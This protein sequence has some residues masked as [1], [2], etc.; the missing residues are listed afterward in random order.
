MNK[1]RLNKTESINSINTKNNIDIKMENTTNTL[2]HLEIIKDVDAYQVF[3]NEKEDCNVYRLILTINPYC[4]NILF[5]TF[6]EITRNEGSKE[7]D[8]NNKLECISDNGE[9]TNGDGRKKN[10]G[11]D[12][13]NRQ[14][15]IMNTEYSK[16]DIGYEYH[17]GYDIF[18]NHIIR[19]L[20]FKLV[21]D[22]TDETINSLSSN[23]TED[24]CGT[25]ISWSDNNTNKQNYLKLI[26]NTIGDVMRYS[27]GRVIQYRKREK[28]DDIPNKDLNKHL[29]LYDDIL[30]YE[31]S[32]NYNLREENGWFGITNNS[33]VSAKVKTDQYKPSTKQLIW[34]DLDIS[35]FINNRENCEFI[36][37]YPDR[38][39]FSFNPILNTFRKR[40]EY[41]WDVILTYPYRNE[42]CHD[43]IMYKDENGNEVNGLKIMS[44]Q[45]NNGT[46]S[47]S[48]V[49]FRTFIKHGLKKTDNVKIFVNGKEIP[50]LFQVT[51]TGNMTDDVSKEEYYFYINDNS[52]LSEYLIDDVQTDIRFRK[53]VNGMDSEYYIRVFKKLPNFKNK[54]EKLTQDIVLDKEKYEN[55]LYGENLN[56]SAVQDYNGKKEAYLIDFNKE[57]YKLAFSRTIYNDASTQITFTDDIDVKYL[58]DNIGRPLHEFYITI[59]KTNNGYKEWYGIEHINDEYRRMSNTDIYNDNV[60]FSHCFGNLTSGFDISNEE[61]DAII[62][63]NENEGN[64]IIYK[65]G[66]IGDIHLL[67]EL[68]L[69]HS[70][71]YE[72]EINNHGS[73]LLKD[74]FYGDIVEFIPLECRENILQ[75]INYRFNTA[76]RE[77]PLD[78]IFNNFVY[79]EIKYDD[80]D[81]KDY[82]ITEN[83]VESYV[84]QYRKE[85]KIWQR[86]EGYYYQAH[87]PITIK[88]FG[89]INQGEHYDISVKSISPKQNGN[90]VLEVISNLTC[91]VA[92]GDIIFLCLDN[93]SSFHSNKKYYFNVTEKIN[94]NTIRISP[95]NKSWNELW[96]EISQD[97]NTAYTQWNWIILCNIIKE[98]KIYENNTE[99]VSYS[100]KLRAKNKSIPFYAKQID[101]NRFLWRDIYKIGEYENTTNE[102]LPYTNNAFYIN[103]EINFFL[104]RQDSHNTHGLYCSNAF[105]NDI[106]GE[107]SKEDIYYYKDDSENL[108]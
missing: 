46:N 104:K 95:Y 91:N 49:I 64:N 58:I 94:K 36:D 74:E 32:I 43:I 102:T 44:F 40:L 84:N 20:T 78:S 105:P 21:N 33:T 75:P 96:M 77:L 80:Y 67:N 7:K 53:V 56:A 72:T 88:E 70:T 3:T 24:F 27:D 8:G 99:T 82:T 6:T 31:D 41:N 22:I 71:P 100:V 10:I 65:K 90:I 76:Q 103:K 26:F 12:E 60:E 34:N 18:T 14:H 13:P 2:P 57:Q 5:N 54:K 55:Y 107:E 68:K 17:L 81:S 28:I 48:I 9:Q 50:S 19:N 37:M 97:T 47:K 25:I 4:T 69:F 45:R 63:D 87:Y 1:L 92:K 89:R 16:E 23:A 98:G 15:M 11:I 38:K 83:K 62:T 66:E 101:H 51:N 52:L 35:R 59:I 108:C 93:Q 73:S 79:Q 86:P 61:T 29:Y 39:L 85:L 106:I 42:Y 30:T